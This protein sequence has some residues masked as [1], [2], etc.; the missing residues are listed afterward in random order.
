MIVVNTE[1]IPGREFDVITL[2]S[3]CAVMCKDFGRDIGASFRNLVGG[4]MKSYS[5]ML[6]EARN[7]SIGYMIED[8][9]RYNADAIVAVHL[10]SS[11]IVQGGAELIAYGTAVKFRQ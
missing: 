3:G 7:K 8:A 5:D 4:E 11:N 10:T 2:V 6:A 1:T 9:Q